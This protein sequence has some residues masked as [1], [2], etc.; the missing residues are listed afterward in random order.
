M[1]GLLSGGAA[2]KSAASSRDTKPRPT[3]LEE[4]DGSVLQTT[5]RLC[6]SLRNATSNKPFIKEFFLICTAAVRRRS[7]R[8]AKPKVQKK[9]H[10]AHTRLDSRSSY[11]KAVRKQ[12]A[13]KRSVD[14]LYMLHDMLTGRVRLRDRERG[15]ANKKSARAQ[16]GKSQLPRA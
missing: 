6:Q 5:C 16:D 13:D 8:S 15:Y 7:P 1:R 9:D 12:N 10:A 14:A 4:S 11:Q 2:R 3:V